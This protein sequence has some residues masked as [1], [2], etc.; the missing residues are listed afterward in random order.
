M[1]TK[2]EYKLIFDKQK[3]Q[4]KKQKNEKQRRNRTVS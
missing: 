2:E 3:E 1:K 4:L